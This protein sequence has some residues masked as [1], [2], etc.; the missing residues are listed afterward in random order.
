MYRKGC[1]ERLWGLIAFIVLVSTGFSAAAELSYAR[2]YTAKVDGGTD[3]TLAELEQ[4]AKEKGTVEVLGFESDPTAPTERSLVRLGEQ[5]FAYPGFTVQART[6]VAKKKAAGKRSSAAF[7]AAGKQGVMAWSEPATAEAPLELTA[8]SA[9]KVLARTRVYPVIDGGQRTD[10]P[11]ISTTTSPEKDLVIVQVFE[12]VDQ[13]PAEEAIQPARPKAKPIAKAR[14][15]AGGAEPES[16]GP[17]T[18]D[19]VSF[20]GD[21]TGLSWSWD[22][23]WWPGDNEEPG[24]FPI[25]IRIDMGA[26]ADVFSHVE[27]EFVL[28]H[29]ASELQV[30]SGSGDLSIDLGAELSAQGSID[31]YLFDPF[32]FDIPYVPQF[33]L[34]VYDQATFSSFLLD[35][36]VTVSDATGRENIV[37]VDL[38]EILLANLIDIPGLGGGV[39]IDASF[40][41]SGE[42]TAESIT[43]TDGNRF[44]SEGQV[45]PVSIGPDGYHEQASYNEILDMTATLTAYPSIY[46]EFLWLDW[47]LPVFNLPWDIVSGQVNI[48]WNMS[49]L[50]YERMYALA[51][52][53]VN[54]QFGQ[55]TIDPEPADANNMTFEAGTEVVL[56]AQPNPDKVFH[57]WKIFDPNF[58]GDET[59]AVLD[60]N[61]STTI[62][63]M[64]DRQVEATFKCGSGI[65]AALPLLV[66]MGLTAGLVARRRRRG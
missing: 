47:S 29:G 34:R 65:D 49:G 56:T 44:Q 7:E 27:G 59:H 26:G 14:E 57:H 30:G 63:M 42:M 3:L 51:L 60:A 43:V 13:E 12:Y 24:G 50:D 19:G 61:L 9:G 6:M 21:L 16:V 2:L 11:R 20:D 8:T 36:S 35:S 1:T 41:A 32:T 54:P 4:I 23:K 40:S 46:V 39:S 31:I 28:D 15:A 33:D 17:F 62:T 66:V 37:N 38:V 52:T 45:L 5:G 10:K 58:P 48:S 64:A 55:I 25:Q 22:T 18:G 53:Q